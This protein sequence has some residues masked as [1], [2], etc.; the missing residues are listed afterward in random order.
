MEIRPEG[1]NDACRRNRRI[2][3][4]Y[5]ING[6]AVRRFGRIHIEGTVFLNDPAIVADYACLIFAVQNRHAKIARR[7]EDE[8]HSCSR[9]TDRTL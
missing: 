9:R 3:S 7:W 2:T 1:W 6:G 8:C 5:A 4:I